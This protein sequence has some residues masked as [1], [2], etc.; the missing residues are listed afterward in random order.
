MK[1]FEIEFVEKEKEDLVLTAEDL[2]IGD[3]FVDIHKL[4]SKDHHVIIRKGPGIVW[5]NLA[6]EKVYVLTLETNEVSWWC[7]KKDKVKLVGKLKGFK[8]ETEQ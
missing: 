4:I 1:T 5:E 8:V 6:N 7:N 2:E 3:V